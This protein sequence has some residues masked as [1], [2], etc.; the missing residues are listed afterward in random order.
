MTTI[1]QVCKDIM[2]ANTDKNMDEVSK[3]IAQTC[4]DL[5]ATGEPGFKAMSYGYARAW[6][7]DFVKR[8]LAPGVIEKVPSR[9]KAPVVKVAA[10]VTLQAAASV[11]EDDGEPLNLS[12]EELNLSDLKDL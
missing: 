11:L 1:T 6:Y 12:D 9:A 10:P 2:N 7:R 5:A 4:T 8:G 3:I